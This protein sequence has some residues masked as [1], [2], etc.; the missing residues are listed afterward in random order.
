MLRVELLELHARSALAAAMDAKDSRP[1]L[2][3]AERD[4]TRLE[5]EG[6]PWALAHARLI[7]AGIAAARHDRSAAISL[8]T[9]AADRFDATWMRLNAASARRRLGHLIGGCRGQ[10]LIVTADRWMTAQRIRVPARMAATC[11]PGFPEEPEPDDEGDT[12]T[13][14]P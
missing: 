10:D 7:R 8:L 2:R 13:A 9:D 14:P 5:G 12:P 1:L 11:A 6:E 3:A 4:A